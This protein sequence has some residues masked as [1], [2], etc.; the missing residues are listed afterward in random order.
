MRLPLEG[1][2]FLGKLNNLPL[3]E[4]SLTL[5]HIVHVN[6][7]HVGPVR[8]LTQVFQLLDGCGHPERVKVER[9]VARK[10]ELRRC[11]ARSPLSDLC[12]LAMRLLAMYR[13]TVCEP[14]RLHN[15]QHGA[16]GEESSA[17][18]HLFRDNSPSS[19]GDNGVDFSE[20]VG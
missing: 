10:D 6:L 7:G 8:L 1:P 13:L 3:H 19:S 4:H 11:G 12:K 14:K 16:D 20:H 15:G 9:F 17:F 2:L 18:F 5:P